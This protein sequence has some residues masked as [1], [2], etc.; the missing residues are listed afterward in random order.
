[1]RVAANDLRLDKE[2]AVESPNTP[3]PMMMIELG[4]TLA[5]YAVYF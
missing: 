3:E 4:I 2:R 5:I 1:M